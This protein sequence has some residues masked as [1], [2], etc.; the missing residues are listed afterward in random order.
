MT[1]LHQ[2]EKYEEMKLRHLDLWNE[3]SALDE[4]E[5]QKLQHHFFAQ[6]ELVQTKKYTFKKF[7]YHDIK[8]IIRSP[9]VYV[10][11]IVGISLPIIIF[12]LFIWTAL[13]LE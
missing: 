7:T 6:I 9:W 13:I 12:V 8:Q 5:A 2:S 4:H 10:S 1:T 3:L 11:L